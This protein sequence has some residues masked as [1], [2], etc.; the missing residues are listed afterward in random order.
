MTLQHGRDGLVARANGE[1]VR[2]QAAFLRPLEYEKG[3]LAAVAT[4]TMARLLRTA[5]NE[6]KVRLEIGEKQVRFEMYTEQRTTRYLVPT[7]DAEATGD[8]DELERLCVLTLRTEHMRSL[9]RDLRHAG[10]RMA[11]EVAHGALLLV[12]RADNAYGEV[13]SKEVH[14]E[15][16]EGCYGVYSSGVMSHFLKSQH[17]SNDLTIVLYGSRLRMVL[18]SDLR[19]TLELD[20]LGGHL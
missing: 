17:V 14:I 3:G 20:E 13:V 16:E 6:Q 2:V 8:L 12:G 19:L 1:G 9:L 15:G 18:E 10:D 4:D 11:V 5:T 7:I